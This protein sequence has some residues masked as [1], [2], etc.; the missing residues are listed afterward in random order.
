VDEKKKN[1][2]ASIHQK[3]LNLARNE[4]RPLNELLQYYA[5][6]RFLYRLG[7]SRHSRNFILKGGQ[8]LKVWNAPLARPTIDIDLLG[9]TDNTTEN[10]EAI[11]RECCLITS[12]DGVI[13]DTESIKGE[14]IRKNDEYQGVRIIVKGAL[15]K[16]RLHLQID[17]GFGDAVI[18]APIEIELPQLLDAGK[19]QLLGYTPES[20]IA[21]KFQ[22]MIV[23]DLTNTRM[24]DFYDIWLL[25]QN[26][27]FDKEI[28][29]KALKETFK[30]RETPLPKSVPKALTS[31]FTLD[32]NKQKQWK[33]FLRKN[34][35]DDGISLE[36]VA[37][38]IKEFIMPIILLKL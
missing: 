21:E 34:R 10:L 29:A 20:S 36:E 8:M 23:L 31:E 7:E 27:E 14:P 24:K 17:F 13:F 18:P 25:S 28:L 6:E 5:I 16:I 9:K 12:D 15:G 33:A 1:L 38:K 2:P 35:L 22:A 32:K 26:L 3:L 30:R 37:G 4:N 19:P 11:V